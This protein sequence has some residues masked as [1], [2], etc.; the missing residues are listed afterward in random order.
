VANA[1]NRTYTVISKIRKAY[2]PERSPYG[3]V[4][5]RIREMGA[6]YLSERT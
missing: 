2:L 3:G 4:H 5:A 6:R 1:V